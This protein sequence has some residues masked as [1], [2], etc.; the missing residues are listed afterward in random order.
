MFALNIDIA[1]NAIM[2]KPKIKNIYILLPLL[3]V[4]LLLLGFRYSI[5][6][7]LAFISLV[8]IL[9]FA[10]KAKKENWSSKKIFWSLY[11]AG[12]IFWAGNTSF[13]I[14]IKP[15]LWS[16]I[17][18][19][20]V[21]ILLYFIWVLI[22][23]SYSTGWFGISYYLSREQ[24]RLS[25]YKTFIIGVP[26]IWA[27]LEYVKA[28]IF[29][30]IF[31]GKGGSIGPIWTMG[32]LGYQ[33]T[34]TPLSYISR[35]IGLYGCSA[36]IV[37]INVCIFY[38]LRKKYKPIIITLISS[39][40]LS[41]IAFIIYQPNGKTINVAAIQLQ[42][43][44]N[45]FYL[46]KIQALSDQK[47]LNKQDISL[48]VL[49]EG[50]P[51]IEQKPNSQYIESLPKSLFRRSDFIA[52]AGGQTSGDGYKS[53]RII[54]TDKLGNKINE[55]E[56]TFL[57]PI[58]EYSP[59][60]LNELFSLLGKNDLKNQYLAYR[61][62]SKGRY[63]EYPFVHNGIAYGTLSCSGIIAPEYYRNITK[64]GSNILID[65]ARLDIFRGSPGFFNQT[66]ETLRY[67]TIANARPL[68]QST[69]GGYSY[70]YDANGKVIANTNNLNTDLIEGAVKTSS[71][72]T[73]YSQFGEFIIPTSIIVLIFMFLG[74]DKK[75]YKMKKH[76]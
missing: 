21:T 74:L 3:S 52:V 43:E 47:S 40:A 75:I 54:Y 60:F 70:I 24:T 18:G 17:S 4:L 12:V 67:Q 7:W 51:F 23:L 1:Y 64:K 36:L 72:N 35:F 19:P 28:F 16:G 33:I 69:Y 76:Q 11:V 31:Y 32:S 68:V 9:I 13:I 55:Q 66:R 37:L 5:L 42:A 65:S 15:Q 25:S 45:E 62:N 61:E 56:K 49:P 6:S 14:S 10:D 46:A 30:I 48:L 41:L 57:I 71:R 63:P 29:S 26:L 34:E 27:I 53:E 44:T 50:T 58:G 8:P 38:T 73:F 39:L 59:Y 2:N 20:L 22:F